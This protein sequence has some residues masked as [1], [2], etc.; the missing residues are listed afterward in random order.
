MQSTNNYEALA[1][2]ILRGAAYR[3][4]ATNGECFE[5]T[6]LSNPPF[7]SCTLGAAFESIDGPYLSWQEVPDFYEVAEGLFD[8]FPCVAERA[9]QC[10]EPTC[11][12]D[13]S[14]HMHWD[15]RDC[16]QD[17]INHLNDEHK[18]SREAIADWI[19]GLA[20]ERRQEVPLDRH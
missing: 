20:H 12:G 15:A 3:P 7:A 2:A 10:P 9:P 14:F 16:L 1:A 8:K 6:T 4:Q 18:W 5:H 13:K 19:S 11:D 17:V